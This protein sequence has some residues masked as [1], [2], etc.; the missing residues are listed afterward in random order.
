MLL[1]VTHFP[2]VFAVTLFEQM[3][4]VRKVSKLNSNTSLRPPSSRTPRVIANLAGSHSLIPHKLDDETRHQLGESGK[5]GLPDLA[6]I[7]NRLEKLD[8]DLSFVKDM[9]QKIME[10]LD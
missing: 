9:V 1:K 5:P 7:R 3:Y 10:K 6:D 2:F 4:C 8:E